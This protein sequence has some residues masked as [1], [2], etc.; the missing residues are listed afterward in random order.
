MTNI[1][2]LGLHPMGRRTNRLSH[3]TDKRTHSGTNAVRFY[4]K[5]ECGSGLYL[6]T[7]KLMETLSFKKQTKQGYP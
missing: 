3:L 4:T 7:A 1:S 5:D 2:I 6:L